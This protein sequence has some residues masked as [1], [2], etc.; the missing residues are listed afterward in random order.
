MMH[1]ALLAQCCQ[2]QPAYIQAELVPCA[3]GGETSTA[4]QAGSRQPLPTEAVVGA[5]E[6]LAQA[7][8]DTV[9]GDY[10]FGGAGSA[11]VP[12]DIQ[13]G[14]QTGRDAGDGL[15]AQESGPSAVAPPGAS[16]PSANSAEQGAIAALVQGGPGED[17]GAV[18]GGQGSVTEVLTP[19]RNAAL[20]KVQ[21]Q[22]RKQVP[23]P[24]DAL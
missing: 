19:E 5:A 9:G 13:R 17:L 4:A 7:S 23:C 3:A 12:L 6:A 24:I 10:G 21:L 20:L 16:G 2:R 18:R 8:A 14:R 15:A 22:A 11:V 1:V